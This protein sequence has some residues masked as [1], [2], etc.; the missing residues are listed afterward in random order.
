MWPIG[1]RHHDLTT[2]RY[3][4]LVADDKGRLTFVNDEDLCVRVYMKLRPDP[5]K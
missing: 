2:N 3:Q 4:R 1:R 5:R